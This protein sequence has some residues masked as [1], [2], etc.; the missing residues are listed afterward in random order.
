MKWVREAPTSEYGLVD[1]IAPK[2]D[3]CQ[4]DQVNYQAGNPRYG[5]ELVEPGNYAQVGGEVES[6]K[7]YGEKSNAPQRIRAPVSG[8]GLG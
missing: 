4:V 3:Y 8:N 2:P 5:H 6:I 7:I 1:R